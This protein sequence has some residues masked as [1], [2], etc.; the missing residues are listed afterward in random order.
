MLSAIGLSADAELVYLG[1]LSAPHLDLPQLAAH[2]DM[3]EDAVRATLDELIDL[4]LV[5]HGNDG[6]RP[7][8]I[9][10]TVGLA[11]LIA[12]AEA[13]V[14]E[15]QRQLEATRTVVMSLAAA[16][17]ETRDREQ[18]TK[19]AGVDAVRGRLEDL[20]ARTTVECVSLNP[21]AAQSPEGKSAS[22]PLNQ[23]MLERG[24]AIRAVYQDSH[25]HNPLLHEYAVWMTAMGAELRT[26]P[27]LPMLLVIFDRRTALLPIDPTDSSKGAQEVHAPGIVAAVYGLFAQIWSTATPLGQAPAC[28]DAD[29]DPQLRELSRLLA[30]GSTDE[31]IAR[32]MG[33]SLRTIKRKSAELMD[34]LDARSRFQAGVIAAQ[35]GWI[36]PG[37]TS[38]RRADAALA[39]SSDV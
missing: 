12:R 10:P 8:T 31:M 24:V 39:P 38:A 34:R 17:E 1:M 29:L 7:R 23:R 5:V 20:A 18:I 2:I 6:A 27:T 3:P 30:C 9:G 22:Q 11:S 16:H 35:R 21:H 4:S 14:E 28:D 19:W 26:A 33:L 32:K 15:K 37:D 25:R 36:E 13:E